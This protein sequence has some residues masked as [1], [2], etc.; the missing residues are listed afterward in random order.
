[1]VC[2]KLLT[3][4]NIS[5]AAKLQLLI[6]FT[7]YGS[8]SFLTLFIVLLDKKFGLKN[9]VSSLQ[10]SRLMYFCAQHQS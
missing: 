5:M 8:I 3:Q 7:S 10:C 2:F 9:I 6:C 1:M 4:I